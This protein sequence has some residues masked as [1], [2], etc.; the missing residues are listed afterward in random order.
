MCI[1]DRCSALYYKVL[2]KLKVSPHK[3]VSRGTMAPEVPVK[4]YVH[5]YSFAVCAS[6]QQLRH[7]PSNTRSRLIRGFHVD[8]QERLNRVLL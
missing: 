5:V 1:R 6:A 2:S 7:L 8:P 4:L 3:S